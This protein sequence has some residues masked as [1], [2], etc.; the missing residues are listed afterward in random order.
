MGSI[1][2]TII[3]THYS[4]HIREYYNG[5]LYIS[6]IVRTYVSTYETIRLLYLCASQNRGFLGVFWVVNTPRLGLAHPIP[7]TWVWSTN[8]ATQ[9][10]ILIAWVEVSL[11]TF[12][13]CLV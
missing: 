7:G 4:I 5:I 10:R 13:A 2:S 11:Y 8:W 9:N 12:S 1:V 6:D 3:K